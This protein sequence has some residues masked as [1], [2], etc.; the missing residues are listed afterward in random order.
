MSGTALVTGFEPFDGHNTNP[1]AEVAKAMD[2]MRI[3]G[4]EVVGLVVPLEYSA[5]LPTV[6]GALS[7][8]APE[9]VVLCGQAYRPVVTVERVAL[10]AVDPYRKDNAGQVPESDAIVPDAPAAY[11]CSADVWALADALC[12]EGIPARVSHHAGTYGCNWLYFHVLHMV[13]TGALGARTVFVHL[14]PLPD[15]VAASGRH[16]LPSMALDLQVRAVTMLVRLLCGPS[17]GR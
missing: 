17:G 16:E 12:K 9:V 14:P 3:G 11:F 7:E 15:Q 10:N 13:H 8:H 5:I 2:G 6:S 4:L 1:S